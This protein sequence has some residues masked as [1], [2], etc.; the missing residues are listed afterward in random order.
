MIEPDDLSSFFCT[1]GTT[2]TPKIA[3]R[4]PRERSGQCMERGPGFR[5][6]HGVR[7]KT[8]FCGLPLFHVNAVLVTGLLPFS[9]GA[10]VM[11]GTP[12][13]YRGEGVVPR[14][15]ELVERHKHQLL[16]RRSD[17][18]RGAAAAARRKDAT[19]AR[20][21]TGCAAPRRCLLE[22]MR[23]FQER[24]GL[25]ILEGYGLTEGTC[26][27]TV[28]PPRGERPPRLD[29]IARAAAADEGGG[30]G[31]RRRVRARLRR[32]RSRRAGDPRPER[33]RGLQGRR[34]QQGA[35]GSMPATVRGG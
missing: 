26:V 22:L 12:Q 9:R 2:G 34:A 11:L 3:M 19:S 13:G 27:S 1:G 30:A 33:V 10:H 6:R 17:G 21:S 31:R 4:T 7:G 8:L 24:T 16:Q 35:C 15:W 32:R 20:S 28:N 5:R 18:L 25:K 29:R 14:F 23:D